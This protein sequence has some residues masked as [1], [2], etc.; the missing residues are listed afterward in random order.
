[1]ATHITLHARAARTL[2]P[3]ALCAL[4]LGAVPASAA[5]TDAALYERPALH[6]E[7]AAR[8]LMLDVTRAGERLLAVGER[9][10]IL[11]SQDNGLSW[12]QM[13]SPVS[14]T[15][16]QVTFAT[17]DQGWAVG[18]AGVILH[19]A[20][21][22]R[23]WIKQLDGNQAAQLVVDAAT[24]ALAERPDEDTRRSWTLPANWWRTALTNRFWPCIF[25]MHNAGWSSGAYGLALA[26]VDGGQHWRSIS[27]Q[28]DNP[29]ALHLY[30]IL[31]IDDT[32]F[33]AAEQGLLLRSNDQGEHFKAIDTP[34]TGTFFGLLAGRGQTLL[35]FG[36]RGKILRSEDL[37]DSW[38]RITNDQPATLTAGAR[39]SDGTL[40]LVDETG[41]VLR[42]QDDGRHF[43]AAPT[44][45]S[46]LTSLSETGDGRFML[47]GVRGL[48]VFS[49]QDGQRSSA[50]E[51]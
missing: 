23:S 17:P 38:Q 10:F 33:I 45:A 6:S 43:S 2:V 18:H 8:S 49:L 21:G 27:Q 4:S 5:Q 16:T 40:L 28:L 47:A 26:T 3:L 22:G 15:L 46:S 39:A 48:S 30:D 41:R 11:R 29:S 37:G 14:V 31:Q 32:L 42:S 19:S 51:Q 24:R 20:D 50:R 12:Q 1:M 9:G 7:L 13:P 34:A 44:Q 35:A 25:S 36:L